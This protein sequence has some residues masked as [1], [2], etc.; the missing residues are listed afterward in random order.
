MVASHRSKS[1]KGVIGLMVTPVQAS[2]RGW[3]RTPAS[4]PEVGGVVFVLPEAD[5]VIGEQR[6][7]GPAEGAGPLHRH[8]AAH[9]LVDADEG[10][11]LVLV[12]VLKRPGAGDAVGAQRDDEAALGR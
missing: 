8:E 1:A 6:D 5:H 7:V 9:Q 2:A 4:S 3:L 11:V 10:V 12:L